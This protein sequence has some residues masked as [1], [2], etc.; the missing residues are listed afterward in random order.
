M[1]SFLCLVLMTVAC[2]DP[3]IQNIQG[4][5]SDVMPNDDADFEEEVIPD[6]DGFDASDGDETIVD[7]A[8]NG[9]T[10]VEEE[11]P[12]WWEEP[13]ETPEREWTWVEFPDTRCADGSPTGLGINLSPGAE[14]AF[15]YLEG[16]GACWDYNT[17]FGI[18][19]TSLHLGGFDES[20]FNGL[21]TT[22]YLEMPLL[23]RNE[24][25]NP[26]ADAHYVFIPYCTGDVFSGDNVTELRGLMPWDRETIY[27]H[28]HRNIQEYLERLVPTF[29][30]VDR[31]ILSG[32][33]AGGFG[34]GVT[35]PTV[36]DAFDDIRVDVLDDSGPP[37]RPGA[38]LWAQW[39]EAWNMQFPEDCL[40]C[41]ESVDGIVEYFRSDLLPTSRFGLIS[42]RNDAVISAFFRLDPLTFSN[43]LG[44]LMDT[45]DEEPNAHYFVI[46]G[47]SHTFL[48]AGY[49]LIQSSN[50]MP[51]WRWVEHMVDDDPDWES[52][53][54]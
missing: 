5:D 54:P 49:E 52:Y 26:L 16:G 4:S 13:V 38:G 24:P 17:C 20:D 34:A 40:A 47:I 42:Y 30:D 18:V 51:L 39:T 48:I 3:S 53:R 21:I 43:R 7:D 6:S 23:D 31:V 32:S 33:S 37:F 11:I 46:D 28:G 19:S 2:S 25:K 9:D 12:E 50:G 35:W 10:D 27:F 36:Q 1:R 41:E 14:Y 29:Q 15:I 22:V 45:F 8:D 44:T